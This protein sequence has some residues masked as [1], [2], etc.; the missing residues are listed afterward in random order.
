ME[1]TSG[2][3][4]SALE[5]PEQASPAQAPAAWQEARH[6]RALDG[7]G[8]GL[9]RAPEGWREL[10]DWEADCVLERDWHGTVPDEQE[11]EAVLLL[12]GAGLLDGL[13][14]SGPGAVHR[15]P[16]AA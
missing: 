6:V 8:G 14:G 7:Q 15:L 9:D 4:G 10:V 5:R 16:V 12:A 11:L 13:V 1:I 3:R 2:A